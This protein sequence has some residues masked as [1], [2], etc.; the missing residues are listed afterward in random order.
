MDYSNITAVAA[1]SPKAQPIRQEDAVAAAALRPAPHVPE[2]ARRADSSQV[3][4]SSGKPFERSVG[5]AR[6]GSGMVVDLII[7]PVGVRFARLFG[8]D[9][10][11]P[12]VDVKA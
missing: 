9:G 5:P 3:P 12:T 4:L 7:P 8:G 2:D 1:R 10:P 11:A 6:D